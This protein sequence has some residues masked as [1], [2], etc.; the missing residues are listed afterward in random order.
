MTLNFPK[1]TESSQKPFFI[2]KQSHFYFISSPRSTLSARWNDP[3]RSNHARWRLIPPRTMSPQGG[4]KATWR[5]CACSWMFV[6]VCSTWFHGVNAVNVTLRPLAS[7][8]NDKERSLYPLRL[9]YWLCLVPRSQHNGTVRWGHVSQPEMRFTPANQLFEARSRPCRY[10]S[11]VASSREMVHS[12][13]IHYIA[14]RT[15]RYT[16]HGIPHDSD[17][18][19]RLIAII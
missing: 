2:I 6:R 3:F 10:F 19:L 4:R 14:S 13:F 5:R 7:L 16:R 15:A 11:P 9:R 8:S 17:G 1:S 18:S 12:Q